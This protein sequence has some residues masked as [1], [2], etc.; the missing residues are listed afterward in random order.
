MG[1]IDLFHIFFC[2]CLT[3]LNDLINKLILSPD[4]LAGIRSRKQTMKIIKI[5]IG[6]NDPERH[7]VTRMSLR[8]HLKMIITIY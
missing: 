1:T 6:E 5:Q 2:F 7:V 3:K 8:R 4:F